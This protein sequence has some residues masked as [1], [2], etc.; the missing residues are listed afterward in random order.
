MQ[1]TKTI[2]A[3][4]VALVA[5]VPC[6]L[7]AQTPAI[8]SLTKVLSRLTDLEKKI[9]VL[10]ELQKL[11]FNSDLEKSKAYGYQVVSLSKLTGNNLALA[12]A[13]KDL[14]VS[15]IM[16]SNFDSSWQY[17]SL[18]KLEYE[19]LV[20][21]SGNKDQS[22]ILEGYAGTVS[23][24]G[25]WYYYQSNMD[26]ATSCL[27]RA[28]ELSE[29]S[30]I[31]KAKANSL[32]TLSFIFMD[33]LRY[34]HALEMQLEALKT[35][36]KLGNQDGIA[37]SYQSLGQI[38]CDFLDKCDL[39]LG[40]YRKSLNL[41]K[42]LGNER[43]MAYVFRLMGDAH[44]KLMALDS[45][46]FYFESAM[47][48][49]EKTGDKRLLADGLSALAMLWGDQGKPYL[50]R[51]EIVERLARVAKEAEYDQALCSAYLSLGEIYME[52]GDYEKSK[53]N[54]EL[55]VPLAT[56][57]KNY[58]F[59]S[60][61]QFQLYT[62]YNEHLKDPGR[63]LGAL[64]AYLVSHDSVFNAEKF[65]AVEDVSTKYETEK[66]EATIAQQELVLQQQ[67]TRFWFIM[68]ILGLSLAGGAMLF[69]LTRILRQ[70]NQEKEFLIK[71][72]HHRVK[73][74]LQVLSSLLYL[75]S[76]H[77]KDDAAL[78]AVREGQNRVEAMGLIHQKLYMGDNLAAVEMRDYLHNLGDTLLDA[79]RL[80][81]NRI[82]ITYHLEPLHLDVDTA[83]PLG[84]IIN[85]LVTNALKYAFPDGREG[86]VE[87]S[88]WKN[89]AGKLCLKVADNGVGRHGA[90]ELKNSTSFGTSLVQLLS[91]KLKGAPQVLDTDGYA[92]LIEFENFKEARK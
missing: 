90:P 60:V 51:I 43:S 23:N 65:Q 49:A 80:D 36:E 55:A 28:I 2:H 74:N 71:E 85:E 86:V 37:R 4:L 50:Q 45:A 75:Q 62:L 82:K 46:A 81:D 72:I 21:R 6:L 67:R 54:Y 5:L 52:Q 30:G 61:A 13:Y 3:E 44:Q 69:R 92:T 27:Q 73:N 11:S 78:D 42:G 40:Y 48:L 26:S 89:D 83:I 22:K 35:F 29:A 77:I 16:V 88:L 70:R 63:A 66:K 34:D 41:K 68:G 58:S 20:Q 14:G 79:F 33:Q 87:I 8:D 7:V 57:L 31:L 24:M 64:Q 91:K 10:G 25:N 15:H 32:G 47:Q 38:N 9:E 39:A 1:T 76:K 59:L 18:A 53:T 17:Y 19:K 84:L 56:Q 12:T